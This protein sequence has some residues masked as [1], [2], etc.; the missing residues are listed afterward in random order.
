MTNFPASCKGGAICIFPSEDRELWDSATGL[1]ELDK[2][3]VYKT[4]A[5]KA[6]V[7]LNH[8]FSFI[9]NVM[10]LLLLKQ[11]V[12]PFLIPLGL[13]LV[14]WASIL[15]T[16]MHILK[17]PIHM[18]KLSMQISLFTCSLYITNVWKKEKFTFLPGAFG[19]ENLLFP[20]IVNEGYR[21]MSRKQMIFLGGL[22]V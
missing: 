10:I 3:A 22:C 4:V 13:R 14:F 9:C 7:S 2:L 20:L 11:L 6:I 18:I 21:H 17:R 15:Q 19:V 5:L 8:Q 12:K 16:H 1:E